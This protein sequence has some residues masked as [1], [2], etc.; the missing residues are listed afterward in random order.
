MDRA[1]STQL[2]SWKQQVRHMPLLVRGARQVGKTFVIEDFGGKHFKDV[3]TLNFEL[4]PEY[5]DCFGSLEPQKICNAIYLATGK[6][7]KPTE[8]LLFFDEIQACP[9][10]IS[11]LRYFKEQMPELHVIGAGSLLEFALNDEKLSIPVGRIQYLYM[12]PLSFHEFL[13]ARGHHELTDFLATINVNDEVP[14]IVHDRLLKLVRDYMILGGMPA[15]IDEYNQ[16]ED[17]SL[18]QN[19]QT[20]LLNTY[21][22]DFGKYASKTNHKYLQKVFEKAPGLVGQQFKYVQID[23]EFR[24]RDLKIAIENLKHAGLINIIYASKA[25]GLPLNTFI[26][27]KKF[28]LNFVDVGLVCRAT[29][30]DAEIMM[31]DDIL[32]VNRGAVAEQFVA[33]ELIA[34][35][36]PY[37]EKELFFWTREKHGSSSEVDFVINIDSQIVPIEVKAG[38][39]GQLKSLHWFLDKKPSKIGI[40]ISQ[41]PLGFDGKILSIP[42]YMISELKRL[43]IS[44]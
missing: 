15:V 3:V 43:V 44:Q 9:K 4:N 25:S 24:S 23:P 36:D 31:Q 26:N 28:K 8:T 17:L 18:C 39:T 30:L 7:I 37:E 5:Q 21:R 1:I 35:A 41:K 32:L 20:V 16:S 27:E 33:Q 2:V 29:K 38:K 40:K 19:I 22:N 34:Y 42:L 13:T 10:A 12:G 6:A 14:N 11:S